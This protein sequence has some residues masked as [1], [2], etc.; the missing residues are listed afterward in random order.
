MDSGMRE[1]CLDQRLQRLI[2]CLADKDLLKEAEHLISDYRNDHPVINDT[3]EEILILLLEVSYYSQIEN[4][5]C[6]GDM[7]KKVTELI[8]VNQTS[9]EAL[10]KLPNLLQRQYYMSAHMY[11]YKQKEFMTC[12]DYTVKLLEV[13]KSEAEEADAY[14]YL[15]RVQGELFE[16]MK[17]I[18][19]LSSAIE[20]YN[21]LSMW[22]KLIRAYV[23]LSALYWDANLFKE[24]EETL[25][26]AL[27]VSN[28]HGIT[29]QL[30]TVYHNL[31]I[32]SRKRDDIEG[33]LEHF[34]KSLAVMKESNRNENILT[35]YRSIINILIELNDIS[36]AKQY[37][38]ES[39]PY[40]EKELDSYLV[41]SFEARIAYSMGHYADFEKR[42]QEV[43]D[44]LYEHKISRL[45]DVHAQE[46]ADHFYKNRQYKK[47]TYYYRIALEYY[48]QRYSKGGRYNK[49]KGR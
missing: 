47:A 3:H 21:H 27:E 8:G 15:G 18:D 36:K 25:K 11:Y 49:K 20:R 42:M 12:H 7:Y 5:S 30:G 6:A 24:S 14:Y 28:E 43:V 41:K 45:V 16:Y 1:D 35:V 31:G 37:L 32:L 9:E 46:L 22:K 40:C 13:S 48:N 44:Y 38:E 23:T 34:T 19:N 29:A 4:L 2:F 10:N 33:A 26:N 39:R 17:G